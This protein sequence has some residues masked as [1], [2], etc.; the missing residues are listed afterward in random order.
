MNV[1]QN[2]QLDL[3]GSVTDG[4]R[5]GSIAMAAYEYVTLMMRQLLF[6]HSSTYPTGDSYLLTLPAEWRFWKSQRRRNQIRLVPSLHPRGS[7]PDAY[8]PILLVNPALVSAF[9]S[10]S[11]ESQ[12]ISAAKATRSPSGALLTDMS[13]SLQ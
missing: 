5:V 11:G 13:A 2:Q 7:R 3:G 9:S 4:I 1:S 6:S 8:L 12:T 10:S